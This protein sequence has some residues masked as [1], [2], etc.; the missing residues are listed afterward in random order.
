MGDVIRILK[1]VSPAQPTICPV[2]SG[3]AYRKPLRTGQTTIYEPFDEGDNADNGIFD[4]VPPAFPVSYAILDTFTT[5]IFDN[6]HGNK[7]RFTDSV[8]GQIFGAGN[9]SIV[10]VMTDHYTNLDWYLEESVSMTWINALTSIEASTD[11]GF[12]D[13][14]MPN[15]KELYSFYNMELSNRGY[16]YEPIITGAIN[17]PAGWLQFQSSQTSKKTTTQIFYIIGSDGRQVTVNKTSTMQSIKVR[18]H[19]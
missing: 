12:S 15:M 14:R 2:P 11:G 6:E 10:G 3:I 17:S 8:G 7:L 13:W 18:N 1:K 19:S 5:L 9:G 4:Y 16:N